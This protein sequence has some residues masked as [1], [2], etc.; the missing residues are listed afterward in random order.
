[1]LESTQMRDRGILVL[2]PSGQLAASDV[3]DFET[4]IHER[5]LNGDLNI[6][7]DFSNVDAIDTLGIHAL[8]SI[9]AKL[10]IKNGQLVLCDTQSNVHSLLKLTACDQV[11]PIVDTYEDAVAHF[12]HA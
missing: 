10:V 9:A 12:Q 2:M 3:Q 6:I 1:M 7:I 4:P 8:L 5:I 11:V